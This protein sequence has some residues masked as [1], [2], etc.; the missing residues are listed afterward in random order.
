VEK[1]EEGS[2]TWEKVT[3]L[4]SGTTMAVKNL[5]EGKKYKFRVKA[6]NIYG[7]GK[8]LETQKPILAK[9]PFGKP[10]SN[11]YRSFMNLYDVRYLQ[12]Y[13]IA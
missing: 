4:S 13:H 6:E 12:V 2:P 11:V 1:Q 9:N 5:K 10:L 7:E 8:P 3:G